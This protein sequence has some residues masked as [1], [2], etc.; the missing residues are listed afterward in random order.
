MGSRHWLNI[1]VVAGVA[2]AVALFLSYRI[3]G[4]TFGQLEFY[5]WPSSILLMATSPADRWQ[6]WLIVGVSV[7]GNGV[8]YGIIGSLASWL[9]GSV[10]AKSRTSRRP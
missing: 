5:V 2:V 1:G 4:N 7:L 3:G 9:W 10:T 8:L 6:D